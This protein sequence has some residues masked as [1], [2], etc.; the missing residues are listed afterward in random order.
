MKPRKRNDE[1][2]ESNA[3]GVRV[4]RKVR[5]LEKKDLN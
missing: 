4:E 5:R 2:E 3:G 1:R